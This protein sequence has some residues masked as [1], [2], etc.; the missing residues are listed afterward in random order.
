M[1]CAQLRYLIQIAKYK[2]I[3]TAAEHLYITP[4]A[5]GESLRKLEKEINLQLFN[6]SHA[7]ISLTKDGE[8]VLADSKKIID[9]I[10][11]WQLLAEKRQEVIAGQVNCVILPQYSSVIIDCMSDLHNSYP[12]IEFIHYET[13]GENILKYLQKNQATIAVLLANN[14]FTIRYLMMFA[15]Q[16]DFMLETITN[17][18]KVCLCLNRQNCLAQNEKISLQDCNN[19][20]LA[21]L[22]EEQEIDN[23]DHTQ[24]FSHEKT[25][26]F[27]TYSELLA[28]ISKNENI[29]TLIPEIVFNKEAGYFKNLTRVYIKEYDFSQPLVILYPNEKHCNAAEKIVLEVLKKN[30][31]SYLKE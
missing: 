13:R 31:L 16:N 22:S 6:R 3:N 2:S 17:T 23:V 29:A 11:S 5:L 15:K 26:L 8:K 9:I 25:F 24:F 19:L 20:I 10:D 14:I 28:M 12:L 7:G 27:H 21:T 18:E 1:L 4:Q 30:I